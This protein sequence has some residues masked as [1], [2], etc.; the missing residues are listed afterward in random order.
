M[1]AREA[2]GALP[3]PGVEGVEEV[4]GRLDSS[5]DLRL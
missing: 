5:V 4:D 3:I 2:E 1:D